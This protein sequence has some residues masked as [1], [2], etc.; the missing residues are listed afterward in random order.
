RMLLLSFRVVLGDLGCVKFRLLVQDH[1]LPLE[2]CPDMTGLL[3]GG[4]SSR[5]FRQRVALGRYCEA[6]VPSERCPAYFVSFLGEF[7]FENF[8]SLNGRFS[9]C[10]VG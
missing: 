8:Q 4:Y 7:A 6:L 2:L 5:Q 9:T 10:Q 1:V 3:P